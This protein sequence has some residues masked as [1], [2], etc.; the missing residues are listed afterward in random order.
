MKHAFL[1][2]SCAAAFSFLAVTAQAQYGPPPSPAAG[3]PSAAPPPAPTMAGKTATQ[4]DADYAANVAKC[5]RLTGPAKND[6]MQDAKTA[7]DRSVNQMSSGTAAAGGAL[8]P[9]TG[10]PVKRN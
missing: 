5:N 1:K 2:L 3:S 8:T 4:A 10:V 7:Y 6:C 9:N